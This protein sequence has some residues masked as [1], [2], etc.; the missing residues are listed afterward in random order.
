K[1]ADCPLFAKKCNPDNAYGALMVSSEGAC[2][3]YYQYRRE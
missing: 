3:A 2:A 1:P